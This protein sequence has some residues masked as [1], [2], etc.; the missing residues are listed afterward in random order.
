MKDLVNG[1]KKYIKDHQCRHLQV[2]QYK[3]LKVQFLYDFIGQYPE[4]FPYYP[5]ESEI[6]KLPKQ[7]IVNVAYSILGSTF[8]AWVK[9][10]IDERNARV[11]EKGDLMIEMDP[12]VHAAF[13]DSTAISLHKGASANMLKVGSKR[14]RT[15]AQVK[16][17][18]EEALLREQ[19]LQ[20]K[21][22]R[23]AE[24]EAKLA[25]YD[26]LAIENMQAKEVIQ[27]LNNEG[28]VD[29]NEDGSISPSKKKQQL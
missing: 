26:R 17:D 11:A 12:E 19:T 4:T 27:Q 21:L 20:T 14:R 10:Q 29:F 24:A 18:K 6:H 16:A 8:S 25:D 15:H 13:M 2:P 23:L 7:W 9:E 28:M 5:D 1:K 22:A 3:S